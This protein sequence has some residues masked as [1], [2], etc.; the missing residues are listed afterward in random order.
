MSITERQEKILNILIQ[1]FINTAKPVSS[2]SLEKRGKFD[3]SPATLR[4][5]M[6]KLT[7]MGYL[8][9]PHTSAGRMPTEKAYRY[10]INIVL[11]YEDNF[12]YNF[13]SKEIENVKKQIEDELKL[14]EELTESLAEISSIMD[15]SYLPEKKTL[16]QILVKLGPSK[17]TYD[18]NINLINSLIKELE[19]F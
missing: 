14:A 18:K 17:M 6:Q 15:V 9:Q 7:D 11:K 8:E 16:F 2:E 13:I 12:F 3:L 19:E 10:F 5:E 4:I 1:D